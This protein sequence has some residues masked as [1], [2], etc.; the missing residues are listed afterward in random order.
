M[1]LKTDLLKADGFTDD[2]IRQVLEHCQAAEAAGL[3]SRQGAFV[4]LNGQV[5][6]ISHTSQ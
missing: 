1:R 4:V 6:G 3:F 5:R 2:E